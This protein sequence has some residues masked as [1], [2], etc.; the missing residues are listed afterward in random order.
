M[1][2][3]NQFKLKIY[4]VYYILIIRFYKKSFTQRTLT[5]NNLGTKP[6]KI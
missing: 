4:F 6:A 3:T 5:P 1:K 2:G